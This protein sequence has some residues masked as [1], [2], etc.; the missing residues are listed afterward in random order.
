MKSRRFF[1]SLAAALRIRG[2]CVM[3]P[4]TRS[5]LVRIVAYDV[6]GTL[7]ENVA[8]ELQPAF[9]GGAMKAGPRETRVLYG[10]YQLSVQVPGFKPVRRDVRL[11]Q[12]ELSVRVTLQVGSIG[13]PHPPAEIGGR[14][15]RPPASGE[16][17]V[18]ATPV[19]GIGGGESLVS[20]WG[21]FLI[22]GLEPGAH[23]L[24]V[25]D[26]DK[27]LHQQVLEPRPAASGSAAVAIDLTTAK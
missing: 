2:E 18:K 19:R 10:A 5:G 3:G 21:F 9:G 8:A 13:C 17:W 22:A 27:V 25:L 4:E 24:T 12:P 26:G 11:H 16:L 23:L 15:Q 14:I 7:I 20:P 6:A 1:F